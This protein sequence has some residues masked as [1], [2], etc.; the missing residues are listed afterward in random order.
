MKLTEV[1]SI[2]GGFTAAV[3]EALQ[4]RVAKEMWLLIQV[5]A[6]KGHAQNSCKI[7]VDGMLVSIMPIYHFRKSKRP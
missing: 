5:E 6:W 1:L 4:T 2:D 7:C 3:S